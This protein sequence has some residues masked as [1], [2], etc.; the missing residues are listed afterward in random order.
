ML[1]VKNLKTGVLKGISFKTKNRVWIIFG[2]NGA[3]KTTLAESIM[4]YRKYEGEIFFNGKKIDDLNI[5]ERAKLGITLMPQILPKYDISV[6]DYLSITVKDVEEKLKILGIPYV[7]KKKVKDLS[8]GERKKVEFIS[9]VFGNFKL[10]ILDEPDSGIDMYTIPEMINIIK[11]SKKEFIIITHRR[12]FI[13][14]GRG[15]VIENGR[16]VFEGEIN[17]FLG[18]KR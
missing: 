10:I 7:L 11:N 3:G 17:E 4:G 12:R 16:I 15:I 18:S 2:R 5:T 9:S 8:G 6:E 13:E 1:E 14:L